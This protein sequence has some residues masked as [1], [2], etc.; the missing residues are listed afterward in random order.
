MIS[1][2]IISYQLTLNLSHMEIISKRFLCFREALR[3]QNTLYYISDFQL[4]QVRY[5]DIR[6]KYI[7]NLLLHSHIKLDRIQSERCAIIGELFEQRII[8]RKHPTVRYYVAYMS[9]T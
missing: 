4:L 5:I 1:R 2:T 7:R 9:H 6:M 8:M 3:K